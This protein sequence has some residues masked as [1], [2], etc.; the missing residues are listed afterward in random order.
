L[1][2]TTLLLPEPLAGATGSAIDIPLILAVTEL[3]WGNQA[4]HALLSSGFG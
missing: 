2:A 1:P 4:A 3:S